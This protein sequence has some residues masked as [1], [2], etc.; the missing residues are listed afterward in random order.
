MFNRV[1]Q[2]RFRFP[3]M[4]R[5][6]RLRFKRVEKKDGDAIFNAFCRDDNPFV[7]IEFKDREK[8]NDWADYS[9]TGAFRSKHAGCDWLMYDDN[10]RLVGLLHYYDLSRETFNNN[11]K[12]CSIGITI[13]A[14]FRR[15]GYGEEAVVALLRYILTKQPD[16]DHILAYTD[17][18]NTASASLFRKLGFSENVTDYLR[19]DDFYYFTLT[20]LELSARFNQTERST[21]LVSRIFQR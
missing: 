16:I 12:R 19:H 6:R 21:P 8:A 20:R 2:R 14:P 13:A 9:A 1:K 15:Q 4:P 18:R 10:N 5:S 7:S 3:A 11:H 17:K